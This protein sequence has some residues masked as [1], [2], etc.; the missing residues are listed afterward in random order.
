MTQDAKQ[1][2]LLVDDDNCTL[3]FL[4]A[5]LSPKGYI[6]RTARSGKEALDVVKKDLPDLILLDVLMPGMNGYEVL[7]RLKKNAR[8]RN[9]AVILVTDREDVESRHKGLR[10]GAADFI[11]KPLGRVELLLRV[12]NL[13]KVKEYQD[14]LIFH[15]MELNQ[16]IAWL[17]RFDE[18]TGLLNRVSAEKEAR[19]LVATCHRLHSCLSVMFLNVDRFKLI[20]DRDGY[21]LGDHLLKAVADRLSLLIQKQDLV[22]R[23][24]G[25]EFLLLLQNTNLYQAAQI[26]ERIRVALALP[27]E[28]ERTPQV[29]TVSI[30]I[31]L[32]PD[33]GANVDLLFKHAKLALYRAK[34]QGRNMYC[35]FTLEMQLKMLRVMQIEKAL[36]TALKEGFFYLHYQPQISLLKENIIGMEALLRWEDPELGL[37]SPDDFI[38][39]AERSGQIYAIGAWVL[40]TALQQ[41]KIWQDQGLPPLILAI[42][43]SAVQFNHMDL[44]PWILTIVNEIKIAPQF[45]EL[46]LTETSTMS[47]PDNSI[48]LMHDFSQAGFR[49]AI[50]DFGTGFS[51]L[52]YLKKFK[53]NKLKIDK[54]FITTMHNNQ[55][56]K[57]IVMAVINMAHNLGLT[58]IAEGVETKQQ[59]AFLREHGCDE[60]Q[61]YYYSKPLSVEQF[62][63]FVREWVSPSDRSTPC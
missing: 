62:E 57:A 10:L 45:V 55:E 47:D 36:K 20:N 17:T 59:L 15:T 5:V 39:I 48:K 51:S 53:V 12:K 32:Y 19:Q 63:Q 49:L 21:D 43:L 9:I 3:L 14:F 35:F 44:L 30:G 31:A 33:D 4:K 56:D 42:N 46:E 8:T 40:R 2:I 41:L 58:V 28:I 27:Y 24:S 61:G 7:K 6:L 25:D 18:L 52:N 23:L 13:L 34:E 1:S 26:A 11:S 60:I 50:D 38:P 37:I 16:H 29:I 54:S 22:A